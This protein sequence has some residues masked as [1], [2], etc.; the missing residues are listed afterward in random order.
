MFTIRRFAAWLGGTMFAALLSLWPGLNADAASFDCAKAKSAEEKA[1][2]ADPKLSKLDAQ[3][4][5]AYHVAL[6]ALSPQG[7]VALRDGQRQWIKYGRDVCAKQ[8]GDLPKL[9]TCL[10]GLY[11]SR[12]DELKNV[13]QKIGP[14]VFSRIDTYAFIPCGSS[15]DDDCQFGE[16]SSHHGTVWR[17]DSPVTSGAKRWN[18]FANETANAFG[19][20]PGM[21]NESFLYVNGASLD[22]ISAYLSEYM[23][24][25]GA[26]HGWSEGRAY[27]IL[28]KT[29]APLRADDLFDKAKGWSSFLLTRV[30]A[31]LEPILQAARQEDPA[32]KYAIP[33]DSNILL[34]VENPERWRLKPIGL[35]IA[36]TT[37]FSGSV[38][39][40]T[41]WVDEILIPWTDLQPYL[42]KP[43]PFRLPQ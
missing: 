30:K 36:L 38:D 25:N 7:Q 35:E 4:G 19:A 33:P 23:E 5:A 32:N 13:T 14:F 18:V 10:A 31:T 17:I 16:G 3:M 9:S 1:V 27:N 40:G 34:I 24:R 15:E 26:R 11:S 43:L 21:N 12:L 29:G 39:L 28:L 41:I 2:C 20:T 8:R 22:L 37:E 6:K 42:R